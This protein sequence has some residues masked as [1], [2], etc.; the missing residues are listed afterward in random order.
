MDLMIAP[1][2][3]IKDPDHILLQ[4]GLMQRFES[5]RYLFIE[6]RRLLCLLHVLTSKEKL[7]D[8]QADLA[9]IS[10]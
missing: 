10:P 1:A 5:E 8:R 3:F 4:L 2:H 9:T 6:Y 7:E